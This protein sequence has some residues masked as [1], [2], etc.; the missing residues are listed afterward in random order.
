[1]TFDKIVDLFDLKTAIKTSTGY[2]VMCP[3][4]RDKNPS[5][6]IDRKDGRTLI[7]CF[8]GCDTSVILERVGLKASD[9]YEDPPKKPLQQEKKQP[10]AIVEKREH[11]YYNADGS[12]FG[13]KVINKQNDGEK[14]CMWLRYEGGEYK[15][16]LKTESGEQLKAPLYNLPAVLAA[17]DTVFIV[18]G[19]K[20]VETVQKMG[21][22][23]TSSPKGGGGRWEDQYTDALLGKAVAIVSDNDTTGRKY[24]DTVA[25]ALI[26][27]A[28]TVKKIDPRTL[29]ADLPE[30]GDVSDIAEAVGLDE[31]KK[32][33]LDA[34]SAAPII[35]QK[36]KKIKSGGNIFELQKPTLTA[37]T[38]TEF[39]EEN[40]ISIRKNLI[41]KRL[42]IRGFEN[43]NKEFLESNI[44]TLVR[45]R[46]ADD[47]KMTTYENVEGSISVI[48]SRNVFNPVIEF[49]ERYTWDGKERTL[50][51]IQLM[52]I[53]RD[54][55]SCE[56]LTRWLYQC[57]V[58]LYN[59]INK[60]F[61]AEGVLILQ[62]EQATG[63]TSLLRALSL[64]DSG[65]PDFF[66]E[67]QSIDFRDK[68]TYIRAVSCWIAELGEIESTFRSDVEKLKAF[69]TQPRDTYRKAYGRADETSLRRTSFAGTCNGDKILVDP[70]G[71]RRF[72][73]IP[74]PRRIPYEEIQKFDF[75][76][77]WKQIQEDFFR[78]RHDYGRSQALFRLTPDQIE[79]LSERNR[80]FEKPLLA[81]PEIED[82]IAADPPRGFERKERYMTVTEF[83]QMHDPLKKYNAVTVGK[84]LEK[85]GYK[86]EIKRIGGAFG[87]Y[88]LLPYNEYRGTTK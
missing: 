17:P 15:K 40:G 38:L 13:K 24:A 19:E 32:R 47:Y 14:R 18:E 42:E 29:Y 76:Q 7:H 63:K 51:L 1:M 80:G 45:Q 25:A 52:G 58:M 50:E 41:T 61:G 44:V 8:G 11:V 71:N 3:C 49:L 62:G 9:L 77:L 36:E 69:V 79:R 43:E 31:A 12:I 39:F 2:K 20:D 70:T 57:I 67:G 86:T 60:P 27:K 16:G 81:L 4:H 48:A 28:K 85:L 10:L 22:A 6:A 66:R 75:V 84:A 73:V 5:L 26:G 88:K 35:A 59:D 23:A 72:W 56:L 64:A 46:V 83:I 78:V 87:K 53:E 34:V 55:L 37:E 82:I 54:P 33:L 65:N 30:K 21:Q 68:D 74:I